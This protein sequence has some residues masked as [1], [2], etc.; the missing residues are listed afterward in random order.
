MI[1]KKY[2]KELLNQKLMN[3]NNEKEVIGGVLIK[4]E[5]TDRIFLL[6]RND[7][8]PVWSLMSGG[9]DEGENIIDGIKR[10]MYEELFV[11]TND[12]IFK[13]IK[14]EYIPNK[15]REFHYFEGFTNIEFKPILD[16][17]NLKYGWFS[18]DNLPSPLYKGLAE[19]IAN[20]YE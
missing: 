17:E 12:I 8:T 19:K 18:K 6:L 9:I 2:I 11:K 16:H 5:T 7:T 13:K 15:N 3:D 14:I 10:E 1:T 20:I 4:C